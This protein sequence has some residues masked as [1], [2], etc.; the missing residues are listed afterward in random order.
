MGIGELGSLFD[1]LDQIGPGSRKALVRLRLGTAF[2]QGF[3]H[4]SCA[5]LLTA[6]IKDLL[7]KLCNKSIGFNAKPDG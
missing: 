3:N 1:V 4:S 7:L 5:D 6:T 2:D